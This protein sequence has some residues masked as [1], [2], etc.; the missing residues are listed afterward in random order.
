METEKMTSEQFAQELLKLMNGPKQST[1]LRERNLKVQNKMLRE[2]KEILSFRENFKRVH[3][4]DMFDA[5]AFPIM[6]SSWSWDK[7]RAKIGKMREADTSSAFTQVLRAG[8]QVGIVDGYVEA[9]TTYEDWCRVVPSKHAFETYTANH[10]VS[11][12]NEVGPEGKY[13]EVGAAML[14][15]QLKNRKYG[16]IYAVQK[17]LLEDDQTGEFQKNSKTLGEYIHVLV[18]I[19]VMG[20]LASPSARPSYGNYTVPASETRPA[21][22][23]NWPWS[24]ALTGGGRTRPASFSVLTQTAV[25]A[26]YVAL[27]Q[28]KNKQGLFMGISPNRLILGSKYQFDAAILLNSS[29]YPSGAAAAGGVGGAFAI[30]PMKSL[31]QPTVTKFMPKFDGSVATFSGD[32]LAWYLTDDKKGA[33]IVQMR[34]ATAVEQEAPNSGQSFESDVIRFKG[35]TRLNADFVDCRFF[36][37][38]NDGTITS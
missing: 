9:D 12:P 31:A 34:E 17:E 4:A 2:G 36:W 14:D 26:G 22:E 8:V 27:Q 5:K 1:P 15:L 19:L 35:Y 21:D 29:Y 38:G 23:A 10:G 7:A 13:P 24:Q 33:M 37:Q 18:E 6:N 3:G 20:K 30:N 11:F 32:S 28:Q 16:A 25:Q